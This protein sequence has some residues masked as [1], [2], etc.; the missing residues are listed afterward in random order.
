MSSPGTSLKDL[1]DAANEAARREAAQWFLLVTLMVYLAVAVGSVTH[2]KLFLEEPIPLPIFNVPMPLTGF[3][4]VA[5]AIFVILHFYVLAQ[6]GVMARKVEASLAKA[7]ETGEP[8]ALI[9]LRLDSFAVAQ[10]L[11][12]RRRGLAP[13][14][15]TA[16][17]WITL[18]IAPVVLLL[19]FQI[20]FLPYHAVAVTWWHRALLAIDIALIWWLWPRQPHAR[21]GLMVRAIA[22]GATLL[23]AA[24]SLVFATVPETPWEEVVDRAPGRLGPYRPDVGEP[25]LATLFARLRGEGGLSEDA[26]ARRRAEQGGSDLPRGMLETLP[27]EPIVAAIRRA[28]FDGPEDQFTRRPTSLFARSLHLRDERFVPAR[29]DDV[30]AVPRTLILI[31]RDLRRAVLD[32]ADLRKAEFTGSNLAGASLRHARLDQARFT[33]AWMPGATLDRATLRDASLHGARLQGARL[34]GA[35]LQRATLDD[36]VL[37]GASLRRATLRGASAIAARG[38][39]A[40]F[41]EANLAAA[42]LRDAVLPAASFSRADMRGAVLSGAELSG[43]DFGGARVDGIDLARARL[44]RTRG[45]D[46]AISGMEATIEH[47]QSIEAP[48]YGTPTP[49]APPGQDDAV[50][51]RLARLS[52]AADAIEDKALL[53]SWQGRPTSAPAEAL[54]TLICEYPYDGDV[55]H[56][57]IRSRRI[58][59][60][61]WI[62]DPDTISLRDHRNC[63]AGRFMPDDDWERMRRSVIALR[64]GE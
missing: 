50:A 38:I 3:F 58:G 31:G 35:E 49:P 13:I 44:W 17:T 26:W 61:R 41:E 28:L 27:E 6:I 54:F 39:A 57:L 24:F 55:V 59:A 60:M 53:R 43:A 2:R 32:H 25:P 19:F 11:V 46:R 62:A 15:L 16:M 23:V 64:R 45:P 52:R 10:V 21:A 4:V 36:A 42:D 22:S 40:G 30:A 18:I 7:D 63:L 47:P 12:A 14:A 8:L 56:G 33:N 1:L 48:P 29:D 34:E 20:R 51:A 5:P 37:D 9:A